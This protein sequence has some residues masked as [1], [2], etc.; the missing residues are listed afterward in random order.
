LVVAEFGTEI[1]GSD[2]RI[3]HAALAEAAFASP[4]DARRLDAIVHPAVHLAVG[5]ALDALALQDHAPRVVVLDVP[6][7]A[8]APEFLDLVDA[9]LVIS[10]HEDARLDR[11]VARGMPEHEAEQR[12]V[13]QASDAERREIADYVIEND[14][15]EVS[16]R[17]AVVGF[18]DDEVAPRVA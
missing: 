14:G 13:C 16:F 15:S 8:E 3:S 12:M 17:A 11:L 9:V 4:A 10:T 7:L 2:G 5:G 6:L 1:L 18:W